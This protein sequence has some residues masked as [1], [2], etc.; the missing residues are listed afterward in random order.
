MNVWRNKWAQCEVVAVR[1]ADDVILDFSIGR[2]LIVSNL[3]ERLAMFG[4]ELRPDKTRRIEFGR[5][6]QENRKRR[7]EGKPETFHFLSFTH[8][9]GRFMGAAHDDS[10]THAGQGC[11]K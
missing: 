3:R 6:A 7:G 4:L 9:S 5:F 10:Q 11:D 2:T 1:Y 8:M